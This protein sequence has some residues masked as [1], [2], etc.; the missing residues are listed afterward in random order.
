MNKTGEVERMKV[1]EV[2]SK[3]YR[4]VLKK[5]FISLMCCP[6]LYGPFQNLSLSLA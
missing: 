2:L 1:N 6:E 4:L 3:D 5:H